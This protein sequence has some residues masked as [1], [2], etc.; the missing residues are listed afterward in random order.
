MIVFKKS[1]D[2]AS[3]LLCSKRQCYDICRFAQSHHG[4]PQKKNAGG[5]CYPESEV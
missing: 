4:R 2:T 1:F 5:Q 3:S